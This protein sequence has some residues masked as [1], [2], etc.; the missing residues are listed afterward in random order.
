MNLK[1][2]ILSDFGLAFCYLFKSY[3]KS[4]VLQSSKISIEN[5]QM[6]GADGNKNAKKSNNSFDGVRFRVNEPRNSGGCVYFKLLSSSQWHSSK[7][8]MLRGQKI[9][10]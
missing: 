3:Q 5:V 6:N 4:R 2:K 9:G 1:K 10:I 8:Q 7:C